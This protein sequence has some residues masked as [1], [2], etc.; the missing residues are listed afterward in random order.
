MRFTL[1]KNEGLLELH[2]QVAGAR[3]TLAGLIVFDDQ[4][5]GG[6]DVGQGAV[7]DHLVAVDVDEVEDFVLVDRWRRRLRPPACRPWRNSGPWR[8]RLCRRSR[9]R[10]RWT[11]AL[12]ARCGIP[13]ATRTSGQGNRGWR[14]T[15]LNSSELPESS[16]RRGP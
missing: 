4:P 7:V 13:A 12:W 9:R 16:C 15:G 10:A 6:G 11:R 3:G 14:P 1:C 2:A 8:R 5:S